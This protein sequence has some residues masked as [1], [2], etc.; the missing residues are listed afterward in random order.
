MSSAAPIPSK[1]EVLKDLDN[2]ASEVEED[3]LEQLAKFGRLLQ[4]ETVHSG[5]DNS[6]MVGLLDSLHAVIEGEHEARRDKEEE[7]SSQTP[8][9]SDKQADLVVDNRPGV[10]ENTEEEEECSPILPAFTSTSI[11]TNCVESKATFEELRNKSSSP[12]QPSRS[13]SDVPSCPQEETDDQARAREDS[14]S[15]KKQ[16]SFV[17]EE[18]VKHHGSNITFYAN[19]SVNDLAELVSSAL[20]S[21]L[22]PYASENKA[23]GST[24]KS[25]DADSG[26]DPSVIAV[27]YVSVMTTEKNKTILRPVFAKKHGSKLNTLAFTI[28]GE[29]LLSSQTND[30]RESSSHNE[31][32][33]ADDL[34]TAHRVTC[35]TVPSE[36]L[37]RGGE[38]PSTASLATDKTE[39][40]SEA[41][42]E[43]EGVEGTGISERSVESQSATFVDNGLSVEDYSVEETSALASTDTE[44]LLNA[45]TTALEYGEQSTLP[46]KACV[47]SKSETRNAGEV[48]RGIEQNSSA[49]TNTETSATIAEMVEE[50]SNEDSSA[51]IETDTGAVERAEAERAEKQTNGN[52][53]TTDSEAESEG[54][55]AAHRSVPI[56]SNGL[57]IEFDVAAMC[58]AMCRAIP[59]VLNQLAIET[60][61]HSL[62]LDRATFMQTEVTQSEQQKSSSKEM[63]N[64][65][66][67]QGQGHEGSA[68]HLEAA[69][70]SSDSTPE[71]KKEEAPAPYVYRLFTPSSFNTTPEPMKEM[72]TP[73]KCRNSTKCNASDCTVNTCAGDTK[74]SVEESDNRALVPFDSHIITL[75]AF[76]GL[77]KD[78]GVLGKSSDTETKSDGGNTIE[79]HYAEI[80]E[81]PLVPFDPQIIT[82]KAF[83]I[84]PLATPSTGAVA[85]RQDETAF[86]EQNTGKASVPLLSQAGTDTSTTHD[87]REMAKEEKA[88][89]PFDSQIVTLK[90][91]KT[92]T[93]DL[94]P[95]GNTASQEN[96][97]VEAAH[98]A[99]PTITVNTSTDVGVDDYGEEK[100]LVPFD[101]QIVTL[102][103]L[104]TTTEDHV[105]NGNTASQENGGVEAAHVA[106]PTIEPNQV[107]TSTDVG[108]DD[109]GPTTETDDQAPAIK[110]MEE[111]R[112]DS[113]VPTD[114]SGHKEATSGSDKETA[115]SRMHKSLPS[116]RTTDLEK[117]V[118][119]Q[120][121]HVEDEKFKLRCT[122]SRP[123]I[124]LMEP[125]PMLLPRRPKLNPKLYQTPKHVGTR[126]GPLKAE[127]MKQL[128][129]QSITNREKTETVEQSNSRV[130]SS[131]SFRSHS[132][133]VTADGNQ[134]QQ[135]YQTAAD[136]QNKQLESTSASKN[137]Q[138]E[139]RSHHS[140]LLSDVTSER[141]VKLSRPK[142]LPATIREAGVR[143]TQQMRK[144]QSEKTS[145]VPKLPK[146]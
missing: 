72:T 87:D 69:T 124:P 62:T 12:I 46:A 59:Q 15:G 6:E 13:E 8:N 77:A 135:S 146:L 58:S 16:V 101:S 27:K 61:T 57:C 107:N 33:V 65:H 103:V 120:Y 41:A 83:K 130:K 81:N 26:S 106:E 1:E 68:T 108:V 122:K 22:A 133:L 88:L 23:C 60:A 44:L 18:G 24:D 111:C 55:L 142:S 140:R 71:E 104:K 145:T 119:P 126:S 92:T 85:K 28:T 30:S 25:P 110:A 96:G 39:T 102:K 47:E 34:G 128:S 134:L 35:P 89:V 80:T 139:N 117:A 127:T 70:P 36:A 20:V 84:S 114:T 143:F 9:W 10:D 141:P 40:S 136:Q 63:E 37:D 21:D 79:T 115:E 52:G 95:N 91:L 51:Q 54:D 97:G 11:N 90:V 2:L 118:N 82:V 144:V 125:L 48:D 53:D 14:K 123:V 99:E 31:S 17:T 93:E 78:V 66:P 98:V 105:P 73:P 109:C 4:L 121:G 42:E 116:F 32:L 94:V 19:M 43:N 138:E 38:K 74:P 45:P 137:G 5:R 56:E 100:A 67:G 131:K 49:Q 3:V 75:K 132:S 112:A 64:A 7:K 29:I 129:R 86:T 76:E 50:Q 113:C